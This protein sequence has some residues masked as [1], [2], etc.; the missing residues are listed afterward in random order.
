[1]RRGSP[2]SVSIHHGLGASCSLTNGVVYSE[3]DARPG[4]IS[5]LGNAFFRKY[6]LGRECPTS[7]LA[8]TDGLSS[9]Q[10]PEFSRCLVLAATHQVVLPVQMVAAGIA[11]VQVSTLAMHIVLPRGRLA[12]GHHQAGRM[13]S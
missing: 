4:P 11:Q 13:A 12:T 2:L 3:G 8:E 1:M 6:F 10:V 9:D 5:P 7:P